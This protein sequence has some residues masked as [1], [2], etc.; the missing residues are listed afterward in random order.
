MYV[1]NVCVFVCVY[2]CVY[3][4]IP[5]HYVNGVKVMNRLQHLSDKAASVFFSVRSLGY[6]AVEQ[7]PACHTAG[8]KRQQEMVRTQSI[9]PIHT[10]VTF[11]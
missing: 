1:C 10:C 3:L 4:Q 7:L 9:Y 8:E 11:S 5:M 6:D 2:V